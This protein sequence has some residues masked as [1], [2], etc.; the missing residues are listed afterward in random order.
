MVSRKDEENYRKQNVA[1]LVRSIF[2]I[3]EREIRVVTRGKN[4]VH[5]KFLKMGEITISLVSNDTS[6][7]REL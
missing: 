2:L 7:R 5:R 3:K 6:K 1:A 4:G